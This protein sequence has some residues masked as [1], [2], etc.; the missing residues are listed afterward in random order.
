MKIVFRNLIPDPVAELPHHE[1]EIWEKD[2]IVFDAG[3]IIQLTA[4][5]GKGKTSLLA[6]IYGLRLDYQG[7]VLIDGKDIREFREKERTRIRRSS[8]S[9][10]FQ[11]LELFDELSAVKNIQ[12]KNRQ[13]KFKTRK[14]IMAM[15]ER[16]EI[17]PFLEKECGKL[18]FGQKQRVAIIRSLCQPFGYLLAD[19]VFSHLDDQT[20]A[21]A[22]ELISEELSLQGAGMLFTGLRE[23]GLFKFD[24]SYRI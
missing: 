10:I 21:K 4:A 5:S 2:E 15:A 7:S 8:L 17:A 18:S 6:I 1:S 16:L 12:L 13:G 9:V 19:E 24:K 3:E 11:G 22:S 14:E 20:A 23:S